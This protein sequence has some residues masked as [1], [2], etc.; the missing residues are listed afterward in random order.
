MWEKDISF[1]PYYRDKEPVMKDKIA[2]IQSKQV[3]NVRNHNENLFIVI[4]LIN[5]VNSAKKLY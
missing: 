4:S 2:L 1:L 5:Y 3:C